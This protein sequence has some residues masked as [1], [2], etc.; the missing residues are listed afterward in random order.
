MT[1]VDN[2]ITLLHWIPVLIAVLGEYKPGLERHNV[3]KEKLMRSIVQNLQVLEATVTTLLR[4]LITSSHTDVPVL[5]LV[6]LNG[7]F[8]HK[9]IKIPF[10]PDSLRIGRRTSA[11]NTAK[12]DNGFF[13]AKV[14]SEQHAEVYADR[15][16][17]IWI[18]D[19]KS[20]N[21]TF[22]NSSGLSS[23]NR[24]SEPYLLRQNDHFAIGNRPRQRGRTNNCPSQ[25][26]GNGRARRH[27]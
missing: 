11:I 4:H 8:E 26:I 5:A 13:D 16:G 23:E 2:K 15:F 3:E 14:L 6:P 25:S 22:V 10:F 17:K 21:G 24:E 7:T 1:S 9:E 20:S 18:K 12:S 27:F 19:T